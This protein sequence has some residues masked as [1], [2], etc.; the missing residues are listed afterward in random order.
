MFSKI[1]TEKMPNAALLVVLPNNCAFLTSDYATRIFNCP[2][3]CLDSYY[4]RQGQCV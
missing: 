1:L 3:F 4:E 2:N